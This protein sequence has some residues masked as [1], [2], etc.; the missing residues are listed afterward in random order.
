MPVIQ[1]APLTEGDAGRLSISTRTAFLLLPRGISFQLTCFTLLVAG[2]NPFGGTLGD[3]G[4]RAGPAQAQ[5]RAVLAGFVQLGPLPC[6]GAPSICSG[7]RSVY[8]S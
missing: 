1:V 3:D 5:G 4:D 6:A 7:E 2:R 8:K